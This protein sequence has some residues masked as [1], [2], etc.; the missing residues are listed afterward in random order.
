MTYQINNAP[1]LFMQMTFLVNEIRIKL[2]GKKVLMFKTIYIKKCGSQFFIQR[3]KY[4][5]IKARTD[6][7][8]NNWLGAFVI[9]N[10]YF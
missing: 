9:I 2:Q 3:C 7:K 1:K 6:H 5:Y 8:S 4:M 10:T